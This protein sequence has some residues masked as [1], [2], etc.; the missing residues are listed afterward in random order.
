MFLRPHP[1]MARLLPAEH[2]IRARQVVAA[3]DRAL[4]VER[5][6]IKFTYGVPWDGPLVERKPYGWAFA[7]ILVIL[8]VVL[9]ACRATGLVHL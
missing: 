1:T 7:S 6:G 9:L 3:A 5:L 4:K 8:A 2:R